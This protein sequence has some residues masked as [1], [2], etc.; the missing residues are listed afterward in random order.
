MVPQTVSTPTL[1]NSRR[2]GHP[3]PRLFSK[4]Q[5]LNSPGRR[6]GHPAKL[7]AERGTSSRPVHFTLP[8][9]RP[10]FAGFLIVRINGL[11]IDTS[12][13]NIYGRVIAQA[14]ALLSEFNL[15]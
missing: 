4:E 1:R 11:E 8:A 6:L 7:Q 14:S 12:D 13:K 3:H 2:V 15:M 10:I 9:A 5:N